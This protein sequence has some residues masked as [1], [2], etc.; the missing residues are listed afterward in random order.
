MQFVNT[1]DYFIDADSMATR[2]RK[3]KVC[4]KC[5]QELSHSA[6]IRHQ[7]PAVC[8]RK[9]LPS[10]SL[11]I[12]DTEHL[13]GDN[14]LDVSPRTANIPFD[15]SSESEFESEVESD[16][17]DGVAVVS[18]IDEFSAEE[19]TNVC[20]PVCSVLHKGDTSLEKSVNTDDEGVSVNATHELLSSNKEQMS[21][22]YTYLFVC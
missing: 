22:C 17:D 1:A 15:S 5:A 9:D 10:N 4:C 3:R 8:P 21:Y 14:E 18:D 13:Y 2:Q 16:V 19:D 12:L 20:T 7:N 11:A 6:F